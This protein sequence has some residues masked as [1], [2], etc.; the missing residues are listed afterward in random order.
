MG[1]M[2]SSVV[3]RN[4]CILPPLPQWAPSPRPLLLPSVTAHNFTQRPTQAP[5]RTQLTTCARTEPAYCTGHCTALQLYCTSVDV[6]RAVRCDHMRQVCVHAQQ[7][8]SSVD[9]GGACRTTTILQHVRSAQRSLIGSVAVR[10][11]RIPAHISRSWYTRSKCVVESSLPSALF[12]CV[13]CVSETLHVERWIASVR[14]A[15]VQHKQ[16]H[17][18]TDDRSNVQA[19]LG[20]CTM[21]CAST[22][23][24]SPGLVRTPEG[25]RGVRVGADVVRNVP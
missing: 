8:A 25:P 15:R 22:R 7:C 23:C 6:L 2:A 3:V 10:L 14:T 18:L 1:C 5:V 17:M 20:M 21:S 12:L 13:T 19:P 16:W 11:T 4:L 9:T 24:G